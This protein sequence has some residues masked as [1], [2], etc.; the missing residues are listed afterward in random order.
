MFTG[1]ALKDEPIDSAPESGRSGAAS[2]STMSLARL[3]AGGDRVATGQLLRAL[4]PRLYRVVRAVL[5][6]TH[7]DLDDVLQQSLIGFVQALPAFRGECDPLG[8]ATIISVRTAVAARKRAHIEQHRRGDPPDAESTA[9]PSSSPGDEVAMQRRKGLLRDLLADLPTEQGEALA[10]RVVLG[11]S[12]KEIADYGH[13]PLNTVRSRLRLAKEAL[14]RKIEAD[15]NLL[16]ALE[17][18]T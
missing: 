1:K 2:V 3:A 17:V 14:R 15:I 12:L 6:G 7:P 8:Y 18:G 9:A 16:D 13:V 11:W 5:G 4:T 10:M